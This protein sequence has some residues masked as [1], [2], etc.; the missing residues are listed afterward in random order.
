MD[1]EYD[2]SGKAADAARTASK[3]A[4]RAAEAAEDFESRFHIRRRLRVAWADVK[5]SAPRTLAGVR[6]FFN[7]PLGAMTFLFLFMVS[8]ES[9]EG[10]IA[11][12]RLGCVR[13]R[14]RAAWG[15]AAGC[16]AAVTAALS[17]RP[18]PL[19]RP[20]RPPASPLSRPP[21]PPAV[22]TGAF[23]VIV[24]WLFSLMWL[25][26]LLGPLIMCDRERDGERQMHASRARRRLP[27]CRHPC[28]QSL[29]PPSA[30]LCPLPSPS[31]SPWPVQQLHER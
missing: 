24:R 16:C 21:R 2:V 29:P 27:A 28:M 20:P 18:P 7:T 23:W 26:I 13:C 30:P 3:S 9:A 10:A 1:A 4:R 15:E 22:T 17:G 14:C 5:R 8:G 31:T 11:Q 25:F 6:D 19:P 12:P